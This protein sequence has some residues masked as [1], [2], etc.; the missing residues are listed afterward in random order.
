MDLPTQIEQR[1]I[2]LGVRTTDVRERFVLGRGPGGQKVNK[3]SS[4]VW[5]RH[6][7]TGTEVRCQSGR[8]R[9][10]NR[11]QAWELLS[12]KL[13]QQRQLQRSKVRQEQEKARRRARPKSRGQ[14]RR[15]IA[16]KRHRSS[17]KANRNRVNP[18]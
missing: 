7:P 9:E 11:I 2:K 16:D 3:T 12:G 6:Q 5:L 17:I 15:M 1:L 18:D 13:E 10:A 8:S 4:T 14:K